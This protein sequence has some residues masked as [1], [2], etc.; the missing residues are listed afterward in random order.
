[1]KLVFPSNREV[2][3]NKL[4]PSTLKTNSYWGYNYYLTNRTADVGPYEGLAQAHPNN[5]GVVLRDN[6][7]LV[8]LILRDL[9]CYSA[10]ILL[11]HV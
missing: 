8:P 3:N 7:R 2:I 5:T 6:I 11:H 10:P 9:Q 1:M 4:G